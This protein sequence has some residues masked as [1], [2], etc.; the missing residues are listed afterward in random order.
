MEERSEDSELGLGRKQTQITKTLPH[1]SQHGHAQGL[2][3]GALAE[4][5]EMKDSWNKNAN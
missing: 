4:K 2:A 3:H 5:R 1:S